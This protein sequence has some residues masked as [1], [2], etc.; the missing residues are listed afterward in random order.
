MVVFSILN[1]IQFAR[2]VFTIGFRHKVKTSTPAVHQKYKSCRRVVAYL[3]YFPWGRT[4]FRSNSY[5]KPILNRKSLVSKWVTAK[6][7]TSLITYAKSYVLCRQFTHSN[8]S[9]G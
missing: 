4:S 8:F 7:P 6:V 9:V 3:R 1:A 2:G 5:G